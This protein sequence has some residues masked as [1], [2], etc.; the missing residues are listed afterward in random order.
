[1]A[2]DCHQFCNSYV[3]N[4]YEVLVHSPDNRV[5]TLIVGK[6]YWFVDLLDKGLVFRS[7]DAIGSIDGFGRHNTSLFSFKDFKG[8]TTVGFHDVRQGIH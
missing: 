6:D 4:S 7:T 8:R 1:M 5:L 2:I 3:N